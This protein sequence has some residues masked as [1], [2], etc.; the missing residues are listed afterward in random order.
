MKMR[1][2]AA[3]AACAFSF[4]AMA[5]TEVNRYGTDVTSDMAL[6]YAG[7]DQRPEWT[8]DEI[9]PYVTHTHADGRRSWLFDGFMFLEFS[10]GS[11]G[12]GFCNGTSGKKA[13]RADW[14]WLLDKTFDPHSKLA[15]LDS[16]ITLAKA[17]LGQPP[18]RHKVVLCV[19]APYIG[20]KRLGQT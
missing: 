6:I 11:T 5:Q 17:E 14:E 13:T 18:M 2:F 20:Q 19:P 7:G 3:A 10:S 4:A 9:A 12:V 16:A 1:Y 8:V 15:A